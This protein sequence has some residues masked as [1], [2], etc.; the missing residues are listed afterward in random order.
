M[1][2]SRSAVFSRSHRVLLSTARPFPSSPSVIPRLVLLRSKSTAA[3]LSDDELQ[4]QPHPPLL[5]HVP[6][7]PVVGSLLKPYSNVPYSLDNAH[8]MKVWPELT[9]KYGDFYTIGIPGTVQC[10]RNEQGRRKKVCFCDDNLYFHLSSFFFSLTTLSYLIRHGSRLTR[11][12][13]CPPRSLR[14]D[15]SLAFRRQ[16]SFIDCHQSMAASQIL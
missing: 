13:S 7:L 3:S 8:S 16:V 15:E 14:N 11:N 5:K 4:L 12:H 2:A 6:S 9:Q 10:K 1:L